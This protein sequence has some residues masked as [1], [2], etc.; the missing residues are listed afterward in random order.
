MAAA[1]EGSCEIIL[2]GSV[3]AENN[4][5]VQ[6]LATDELIS[7]RIPLHQPLLPWTYHSRMNDCFLVADDRLAW[8]S[9]GQQ[10]NLK[11]DQWDVLIYN[12]NRFQTG[13]PQ[14]N[15]RT[16]KLSYLPVEQHP[17]CATY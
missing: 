17:N 1:D 10:P 5:C 12:S 13:C 15:K 16:Q 9:E 6:A 8:Y 7:F 11:P 3:R 14:Y 4:A 2:D